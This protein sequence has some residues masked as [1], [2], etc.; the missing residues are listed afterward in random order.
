[1][2]QAG[3]SAQDLSIPAPSG[4]EEGAILKPERDPEERLP[5]F[6]RD[7]APTSSIDRGRE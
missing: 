5:F 1:V 4:T 7:Q 2:V 6:A 3:A